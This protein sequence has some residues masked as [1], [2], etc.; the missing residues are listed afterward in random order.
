LL[1]NHQIERGD[2]IVRGKHTVYLLFTSVVLLSVTSLVGCNGLKLNSNWPDREVVIDGMDGEWSGSMYYIDKKKVAVGL[3]NDEEYMYL[4]LATVDFRQVQQIIRSGLTV[5]FDPQGGKKESF[6]VNFPLGMQFSPENMDRESMPQ[7]MSREGAADPEKLWQMFEQSAKEM[8]IIGPGK[9][10]RRRMPVAASREIKV[11]MGYFEGKLVYE[12]RVPLVQDEKYPQ[13]IGMDVSEPIGVG[14]ETAELDREPMRE[15]MS[16][17]MPSGGR[18]MRGGGGKGGG[19]R[20][21]GGRGGRGS[22]GG[23]APRRLELW[24]KVELASGSASAA[25]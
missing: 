12:L 24:T 4:C 17:G 14:F 23:E 18:G 13:A 15:K 21:G 8:I 6:G 19:G 22:R 3:L 16:G 2:L 11:R 20:S 9:E 7:P 1:T 5:W 10:E 25:E